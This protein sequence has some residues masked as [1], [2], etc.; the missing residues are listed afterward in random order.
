MSPTCGTC[1]REFNAGYDGGFKARNSHCQAL[2]H[3][4]PDFECDTCDEYF[5]D[6]DDRREHMDFYGHWPDDA[7]ECHM[8]YDRFSNKTERKDHEHREH[9]YCAECDREFNNWNNIQQHLNSSRHRGSVIECPFCKKT[10]GTATG[11]THHL[12]RG[13]CPKAPLDR[14]RLYRAVRERDPQ[15]I[16]SNKTI[17]WYGEKTFEASGKSWNSKF[18]AYECYLCHQLFNALHSLNSHLTSPRHQ[19]NL[20]HCPGRPC[21]KEFTTLAG[22]VNHLESESCGYMRFQAVQS[23]IRHLVSSNRRITM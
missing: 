6:E 13:S 1:W 23:G 10:C 20:Y 4:F 12:E 5:D 2:G 19:Q 18:E 7:P 11:L 3:S 15:G 8:C 22:L 17:E 21:R 14:D 16:I 9:L